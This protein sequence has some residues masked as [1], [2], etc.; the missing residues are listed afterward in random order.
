MSAHAPSD[1]F[2]RLR[3]T[4]ERVAQGMTDGLH[5]GAQVYVSLRGEVIADAAM[6]ESQDG[7]PM[8]PDTV[9]RWLSAGK[10]VAAVAIAR[11]EER[12]VVEYDR[13][14]AHYIPA[15]AQ[16]G[17]GMVT[18][19]HL[20]THTG[21]IRTAEGASALPTWDERIAAICAAPLEAGWTP[22][23]KAAYHP[24]SGWLIL[25]EVVRQASGLPYEDYVRKHIFGP[26]GM[27]DSWATATPELV[28]RY[29]D[30]WSELYQTEGGQR[31]LHP[32][33]LTAVSGY[34]CRPGSTLRGPAHDLGRFY[35]MLLGHGAPFVLSL[36]KGERVIEHSVRAISA[37]SASAITTPQ[38]IGMF[39]E[40][41]RH[42]MD[43]GLG[44]IIDSKKYGPGVPYGFG[45]YASARTF[46][47]GGSQ[48]SLG[49][50]DPDHG[51]A[52][53]IVFN[54][55]PGEARHDR[56]MKRVTS[57]L[58]EDLGLAQAM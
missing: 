13:A 56:R 45:P 58:Y 53:A 43:W 12:G 22:G 6:G 46:G 38:R 44:V 34:V 37:G 48:S 54:G 40:T 42:V 8:R 41:F 27:K 51:L 55:L 31:V 33:H 3:Q 15:F 47:H 26:L 30:R 49:F 21:G 7:V 23:E 19:R 50:A 52:A 5:T 36:S 29:G 1:D 39:D 35:E 2:D 18:L 10:P 25:G 11:L 17:K 16:G 20:L 28:R 4:R 57:A 32:R 24:N 14:V 9:Q